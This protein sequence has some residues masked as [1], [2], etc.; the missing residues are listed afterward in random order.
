MKIR[1]YAIKECDNIHD[2]SNK[3]FIY[4]AEDFGYV[5]SLSDFQNELNQEGSYI[6]LVPLL[7][8]L[9]NMD[10]HFRFINVEI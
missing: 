3:D 8:R 10:L 5:W 2:I 9:K 7:D 1:V 4:K 6:G